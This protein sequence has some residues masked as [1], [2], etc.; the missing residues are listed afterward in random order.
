MECP[1]AGWTI[2]DEKNHKDVKDKPDEV[3]KGVKM[4]VY[5]G[6]NKDDDVQFKVRYPSFGNSK[7][8]TICMVEAKLSGSKTNQG[9]LQLIS[10]IYQ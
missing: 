9:S 3:R 5:T 4:L 7:E 8:I 2:L 1:R 10:Q 6:S